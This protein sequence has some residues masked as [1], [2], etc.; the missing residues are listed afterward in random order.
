VAGKRTNNDRSIKRDSTT[1]CF[2]EKTTTTDKKY[3]RRDAAGQFATQ[4][5][6]GNAAT[7]VKGE[8]KADRMFRRA[9]KD[10]YEKRDRRVG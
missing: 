3:V 8:S 10:T 9:W 1:G 5:S 4:K 2:D 7:S 6:T